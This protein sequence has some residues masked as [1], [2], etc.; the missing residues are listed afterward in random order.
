VS[1]RL[2]NSVTVGGVTG[3]A[4]RSTWVKVRSVKNAID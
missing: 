4:D 1:L 2:V 3:V